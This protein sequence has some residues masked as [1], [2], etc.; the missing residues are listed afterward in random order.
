MLRYLF[1]IIALYATMPFSHT[2]DVATVIVFFVLIEEDER[3]ALCFAFLAG[4]VSDLYFPVRLGANTLTGITLG[5]ALILLKKYLVLNPLTTLATFIVFY[6]LKTAILN[7]AV[8]SP[9][10]PMRILYTILI[11][12]PT[13]LLLRRTLLGV[14]MKE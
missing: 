1:Y 9:I 2:V 11:A 4:L 7:V 12:F 10:E 6:F 3:F 14:W 8:S 5:Q 13:L